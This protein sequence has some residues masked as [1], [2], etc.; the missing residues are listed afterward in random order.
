MPSELVVLARRRTRE[1][2]LEILFCAAAA[3]SESDS[4]TVSSPGSFLWQQ[5]QRPPWLQQQ[6]SVGKM[7]RVRGSKGLD[8]SDVTMLT[9]VTLHHRS[10]VNTLVCLLAAVALDMG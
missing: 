8:Q 10:Q 9:L 1:L 6:L 7:I 4:G 5:V 3:L 2:S